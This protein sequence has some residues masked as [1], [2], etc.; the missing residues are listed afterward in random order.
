[1]DKNRLSYLFACYLTKSCSKS[2]LREFYALLVDAQYE[3]ELLALMERNLREDLEEVVLTE[4]SKSDVL[5]QVFAQTDPAISK[6][7][8]VIRLLSDWRKIAVVACV[9]VI[10]TY[11]YLQ[12]DV[13]QH[14]P[15]AKQT[16][17]DAQT[18]IQKPKDNAGTI[19]LSDGRII[20]LKR[21]QQELTFE[22]QEM[23]YA[24]GTSIVGGSEELKNENS[25]QVLNTPRGGQYKLILSDGTKVWLNAASSLRFPTRFAGMPERIVELTGEAYFDVSTVRGKHKIP[26]KVLSKGQ[27]VNVLGTQ[28]N[29]SAY[30]TQSNRTVTTLIEG[31]VRLSNG[32]VTKMLTPG[33]QAVMTDRLL[34]QKVDVEEYTSWKEGVFF[35]RDKNLLEILPLLERWYD[36]EF[37]CVGNVRDVK[38]HLKVSKDKSLNQLLDII[39]QTSDLNYKIMGR[40][41]IIER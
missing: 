16:V 19:T 12:R 35:V 6:G 5:E 27:E 39:K 37:E 34:V 26:F 11:L 31:S 9:L 1:M 25:Y 32:T 7:Q 28:F 41:V 30:A 10:G 22:D 17:A 40:R 2:E 23:R 8:K 24:D 36:V 33:D 29:I 18:I 14:T 38:L 20:A 21:D 4:K 3:A 15:D 13:Q